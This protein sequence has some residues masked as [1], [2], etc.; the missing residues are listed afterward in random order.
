M[1]SSSYSTPRLDPSNFKSGPLSD[2]HPA[3]RLRQMLARGHTIVAPGVYDG[4]SARCVLGDGGF[5]AMYMSGAATTASRL[6]QPDVAIATLNDF[7][8]TA[9]M[10]CSLRPSMPVIADA[11]T[12]FGG[13]AMIARTVKQYIRAGLAGL[14]IEDQVQSKRCGHLGGKQL[15]SREEFAMRI[16]AAVL[17][18]DEVVG[19]D[20]IIIARSDALQV[21]GFDEAIAR[22][23]LASSCGA[24]VLFLEGVHNLDQVRTTV[25][26]FSPKPILLNIVAGGVSP[27]F[28]VSQAKEIGVGICIFP[29]V[30]AVAAVHAIRNALEAVKET[31]SDESIVKGMGPKAF[32]E[33]MGLEGVTE[34]DEKVGGVAFKGV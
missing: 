22:L 16:R 14:H 5:E 15:V 32:F 11:D 31:G 10:I 17:A 23:Q 8:Q 28:M 30:G 19:S 13:P 3:T 21:H 34:F 1:E 25:Q 20:F 12:G 9:E 2:I 18:R 24:D 27:N 33:V 26:T 4:I 7:V 29:I 6:G